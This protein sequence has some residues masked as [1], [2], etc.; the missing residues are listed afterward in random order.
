VANQI[1]EEPVFKWW[2]SDTLHKQNHI[3]TLKGEKHYW[4]NTLFWY[5]VAAFHR[6]WFKINR[7]MGMEHWRKTLNKEMLKVKI[8]LN[9]KDS[10][11]P[12][13]MRLGKQRK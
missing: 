1:A 3:I 10:I 4:K 8:A 9:T 5:Q 11:T 12:E 6:R 2:V 13:D 7:V